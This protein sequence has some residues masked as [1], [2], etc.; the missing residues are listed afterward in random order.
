LGYGSGTSGTLRVNG[1]LQ[2]TISG[3]LTIGTSGGTGSLTESAGGS[4]SAAT[5]NLYGTG[6]KSNA[7]TLGAND[8]VGTVNL[9]GTKASLT[10]R[11]MGT[12]T[13][14]GTIAAG[15]A[16][17]LGAAMTLGSGG[18]NVQDSGSRL[19][20]G[21]YGLTAGT[22]NLGWNGT[23]AVNFSRGNGALTV[24]NLYL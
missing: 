7:L 14:G 8:V 17:N 23:S 4:F 15:S 20:M 22:L 9:S 24:T 10:T 6:S 19:S 21:N 13:G 3:G 12:S 2:L 1:N 16:L 11:A 18:L 5:L